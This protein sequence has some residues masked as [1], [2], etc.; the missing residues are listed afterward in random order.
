MYEIILSNRFRRDL[1]L[2]RRRGYNLDLLNSVVETHTDLF[3]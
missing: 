1:K 2:A 3:D